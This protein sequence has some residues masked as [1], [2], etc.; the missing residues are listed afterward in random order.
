MGEWIAWVAGTVVAAL[1]IAVAGWGAN[2]FMQT[3]RVKRQPRWRALP[4][5]DGTGLGVHL[6][7]VW[8]ME[9]EAADVAL[10]PD[11]PVR[12]TSSGGTTR[13][14]LKTG[15]SVEAVLRWDQLVEH[16]TATITWRE[17]GASGVFSETLD[18]TGMVA[19]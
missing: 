9:A 10:T 4:R 15:E 6:R 16:A 12:Q 14:V 5:I 2:K 8:L 17:T 11:P 3:R 18:L 19:R 1:L 13:Q 7:M